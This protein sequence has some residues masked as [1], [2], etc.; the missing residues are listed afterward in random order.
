MSSFAGNTINKII[1]DDIIIFVDRPGENTQ[2]A[3]TG[4]ISVNTPATQR[5][6]MSSERTGSIPEKTYEPL[7]VG[8][9]RIGGVTIFGDSQNIS[10][11][12]GFRQGYNVK[13]MQHFGKGI[14]NFISVNSKNLFN[15]DGTIDHKMENL[16]F[17][18][19]SLFRSFENSTQN[20]IP[21]QDFPGRLDPVAYVSASHYIMQYMILT[22]L[23][24][25][26]DKFIDPDNMDGVIEVF[27][28]RRRFAN[29]SIADI[30][31]R[32]V[33]ADLCT[34]DI[35][36][37]GK[38]S[39]ILD[40]KFEK[41]Q[42]T[43]DYF[44]DAQDIIFSIAN[45]SSSSLHNTPGTTNRKF[46]L[47]G[48]ISDGTYQSS[49]FNESRTTISNRSVFGLRNFI[50]SN[51]ES[52]PKI[53]ATATLTCVDG[54]EN[55]ARQFTEQQRIEITSSDGIK[56]IYVITD[57]SESGA[58]ATGTVLSAGSD[59]GRSK[60]PR[61][62]SDL[63]DC[64]AVSFNL[65]T[66]TQAAALNEFRKAI[67]HSNGHNGKIASSAELSPANGPQ[68]I[69]LTQSTKGASGNKLIQKNVRLFTVSG[70]SGGNKFISGSFDSERSFS[71]IGS[72][73]TSANTGI[74]IGNTVASG[75]SSGVKT[76]LG[77]DSIAF[78]GFLK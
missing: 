37:D 69:T 6:G 64:V 60:L 20:F 35:N 18:Q 56:K 76:F 11:I 61:V 59:T 32:G 75:S 41:I 77:T 63:G 52:I 28:I 1:N 55:A 3:P 43:Y 14:L 68:T 73:Y 31:L 13:N 8:G 54:D 12:D 53:A 51:N 50:E 30:E 24:R 45:F 44:E 29:T 47:P 46:S 21:F 38:G 26:I 70:F 15:V 5:L 36:F 33:K 74:I 9:S 62:I 39:S 23:T 27:D 16:S 57:S 25:D 10:E 58:A 34:G 65:S 72:R 17:G 7:D 67:L 4:L 40:T 48:F 49:P 2:N 22:D 78:G 42:S 19:S 71:L 66:A